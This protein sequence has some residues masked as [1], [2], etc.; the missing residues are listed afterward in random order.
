MWLA[1]DATQHCNVCLATSFDKRAQVRTWQPEKEDG[2][3]FLEGMGDESVTANGAQH[4][5]V[6][7]VALQVGSDINTRERSTAPPVFGL[8]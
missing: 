4:I 3:A 6:Q 8:R 2:E 5:S 7:H 1:E